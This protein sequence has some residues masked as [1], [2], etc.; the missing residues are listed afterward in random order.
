MF[1]GKKI[2]LSRCLKILAFLLAILFTDEQLYGRCR[3]TNSS[4][5]LPPRILLATPIVS[6]TTATCTAAGTAFITNYSPANTY[7]FNPAG[8]VASSG[9][10]ITGMVEGTSYTVTANNAG[11]SSAPS[12]AF[13]ISAP[14][15]APSAPI[16]NT[17]AATCITAGSASITNFS[18]TTIYVFNPAGPW[19][20]SD[21]VIHGTTPGTNYVVTASIGGCTTELT[22]AAFS[23]SPILPAA[24]RPIV[25]T[26]PATCT[27]A[28]S[29]TVSNYSASSVYEVTPAGPS[30]T[31]GGAING[32]TAG[33][34][35]VVTSTDGGCT[36]TI[37]DLFNVSSPVTMP[38]LP[39]IETTGATCDNAGSATIKNYNPANAYVFIPAGPTVSATGLIIGMSPGQ[40]YTVSAGNGGCATPA[41]A[42]FSILP[43][44]SEAPAPIIKLI[45]PTC[46]NTGA[47][48]IT[49]YNPAAIYTFN[50]AGPTVSP[51]GVIHGMDPETSYTVTA[52]IG[53]CTSGPSNVIRI[54]APLA[55]APKPVVSIMEATCSAAGTATITNYY[56]AATYLFNPSGPAVSSNGV[57]T[58]MMAGIDYA[59]NA[60]IDGCTP[61]EALS[62]F[63]IQGP[64]MTI[65]APVINT[66]AA[67]CTTAG[68]ATI[69][70][71]NATAIYSFVPSGPL[72]ASNGLIL[73]MIEGTSYSVTA[74]NGIC[75]TVPSAVFQIGAALSAIAA[76]TI[77]ITAAACTAAGT[78]SISNYNAAVTYIFNPAGPI[79]STGGNMLGLLPGTNYIVIAK[80]G[81]CP[82]VVQSVL[83]SVP[84]PLATLA[85]PTISSSTA[86]CATAGAATITNYN[87]IAAY[88]F[89][90]AG[91]TVS[92]GGVILGMAI[93]TNYAVTASSGGCTT[94]PSGL[95]SIS[96]PLNTLSSPEIEVTDPTCTAP[97]TAWITNF[98]ASN[99]YAFD[100]AGPTISTGGTILGMA[101][102][103]RYTVIASNGGCT[104]T[105][106]AFFSIGPKKTA[107]SAPIIST[108]AA[109]C[110]LGGMSA[111][112]NYNNA[113]VY[114]FKP[115]GPS[116][117]AG[118]VIN[119]A[120]AGK[121]YA[122]SAASS[123]CVSATPASFIN[124]PVKPLPILAV[125][126]S[127]NIDCATVTSKLTASS[128]YTYNWSPAAS[129]NNSHISNPV[130]SPAS[131][132]TYHVLVTN[133]AGC[134]KEDSIT[135]EVQKDKVE[136]RYQVAT[137][138]TP[139]NDGRNDCFGVPYWGIVTNFRFTI[140]NRWGEIVFQTN[141]ISQCWDG[142]YKGIEQGATGF[143]Y[144]I[145]ADT[146]CGSVFRK[147]IVILVR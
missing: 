36:A 1:V 54:L 99:G 47:A 60:Y 57:I 127:N 91:P 125:T 140:Y 98:D 49:N 109:T 112:E 101:E 85:T 130:A 64:L 93:G 45:V 84:P 13:S 119:G 72:V 26:S 50:P 122:V 35:Y 128:G 143:P 73:G 121:W 87:G 31:A 67:A 40:N 141:D 139:N 74:S 55:A 9:G 25:V 42:V 30:I 34:D 110:Y 21:G 14:L 147:G 94:A 19:L 48:S 59:V 104:T 11:F 6:I 39:E 103:T 92:A 5:A 120:A 113:N 142:K 18:A 95:F 82:A 70:N 8:P 20:L 32:L 44:F 38:A 37:S 116:V 33:V 96:A 83:F 89:Y 10:A 16:V 138:F 15:A 68:T 65:A 24:A 79:V 80:A 53:V 123:G 137:A 71:Y 88:T 29:A 46:A 117:E 66:S 28:G 51:D 106:S 23:V 3:C 41:S 81:D 135:V 114:M 97:G 22:S 86:G 4:I 77:N 62:V 63:S 126:K 102:G 52:T 75:T 2:L 118:G 129:L 146:K 131:T 43:A 76:P 17:T 7:M 105:P 144:I 134:V 111:I 115:A 90:P 124:E 78:A 108:A 56:E 145:Y 12:G 58:G 61:A 132:T 107:P 136:N 100:P 69:T 133:T 27:A